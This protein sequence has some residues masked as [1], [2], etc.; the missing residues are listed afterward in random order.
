[1]LPQHERRKAYKSLNKREN[2]TLS[3]KKQTWKVHNCMCQIEK[4][5]KKAEKPQNKEKNETENKQENKSAINEES[6]KGIKI[7]VCK[8]QNEDKTQNSLARKSL[9]LALPEH[10]TMYKKVKSTRTHP[11]KSV[12]NQKIVNIFSY[13]P[14][15]KNLN[16]SKFNENDQLNKYIPKKQ[17]HE[18]E[19]IKEKLTLESVKITQETSLN[20]QEN[21]ITNNKIKDSINENKIG[22]N[23]IIV[24]KARNYL[25]ISDKSVS[26]P[27]TQKETK[28]AQNIET[29][30]SLIDENKIMKEKVIL[31][32][33]KDTMSNK[34]CKY[35]CKNSDTNE[36][37]QETDPNQKEICLCRHNLP[38]ES[39]NDKIDYSSTQNDNIANVTQYQ[40]NL[41]QYS[42]N[43][44]RIIKVLT[45]IF[46]KEPFNV[47]ECSDYFELNLICTIL[48][49]K[50][51]KKWVNYKIKYIPELQDEL[52]KA[53]S[54]FGEGKPKRCDEINS[55]IFKKSFKY[56]IKKYQSCHWGMTPE[57]IEY[58]FFFELL[59]K[60]FDP[61]EANILRKRCKFISRERITKFISK[62]YFSNIM[63][64]YIYLPTPEECDLIKDYKCSIEKKFNKIFKRWEN[65]VFS[66]EELD[67][68]K[69]DMIFYFEEYKGCKIPWACKEIIYA[70][71]NFRK[72][73]SE[74]FL[75]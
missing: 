32:Q 7:N 6:T 4:D 72:R 68:L 8:L 24:L 2:K 49:R 31:Y 67:T 46:L 5:S 57:E 17:H 1:M 22:E 33:L 39:E 13:P 43:F 26:L 30:N 36:N 29:E 37:H 51:K 19:K 3:P 40:N 47:E 59:G 23:P 27:S 44:Y 60:G 62:K 35:D 74:Y 25:I 28:F 11:S 21:P 73:F 38:E 54:Y 64:D 58:S 48:A 10:F 41:S 42:I 53:L 75:K 56:A 61:E 12:E 20:N 63:T 18:N 16:N 50:M 34:P 70:I 15:I 65:T 66:P 55:F 52:R 14:K 45:Q 71:K 69:S 9:K